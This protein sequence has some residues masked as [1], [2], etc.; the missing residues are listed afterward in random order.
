MG[1]FPLEGSPLVGFYSTLGLA[2]LHDAASIPPVTGVLCL[3]YLLWLF[4]GFILVGGHNMVASVGD[5]L[6]SLT[7]LTP[8]ASPRLPHIQLTPVQRERL[9]ALQSRIG[10]PYNGHHKSHQVC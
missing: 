6:A 4:P 10:V 5:S 9:T 7:R 8:V 2:M 1:F 3:R